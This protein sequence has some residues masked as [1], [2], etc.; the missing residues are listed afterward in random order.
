MS[1]IDPFQLLNLLS[2]DQFCSGED[3]AKNLGVSR[4]AI[5]KQIKMLQESGVEIYSVHRRGYKLQAS[6]LL[7]DKAR[8]LALLEWD[9]EALLDIQFIVDSTNE[10]VKARVNQLDNGH[11]CIAEAQKQGKGRQGKVWHSPLGTSIY[12]SMK[13]GFPLGVQSLSGLSLAIGVSI[14]RVLTPLVTAPVSLKWPNDVYVDGKKIAGVLIEVVGNTDGSCE[15]IIGV[16]LNLRVPDNTVIDQPWTD[17]CQHTEQSVDKSEFVA[18]LINELRKTLLIFSETGL[19]DFV[20][21]WESHDHFRDRHIKLLLGQNA[22]K[23]TA[24][25]ISHS[26]ALLVDVE[27]SD[28]KE[29]RE[30]F[31]GEISVRPV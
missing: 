8:V 11:T 12:L 17:L 2:A 4:T 14:V 21:D 18:G 3:I 22:I 31:G 26:G 10:L 29:R 27:T 19:A 7:Y 15:A 23:G 25:G 16:G 30:F 6:P 13:W 28:G 5:A 1:K 24:R 9:D 20:A